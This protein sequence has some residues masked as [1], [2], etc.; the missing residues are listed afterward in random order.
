MWSLLST[1]Q[2]N[3]VRWSTASCALTLASQPYV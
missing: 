2:E 3:F 1:W